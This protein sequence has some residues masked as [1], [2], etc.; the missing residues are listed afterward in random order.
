MRIVSAALLMAMLG[1]CVT[2][3]PIVA[4]TNSCPM[5]I[6]DT[7]REPVAAPP[8][9]E[10]LTVGDWI[11]FADAVVGKLDIANGRNADTLTIIERCTAR[12]AAAVKRS[13]SRFLGVL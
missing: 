5:L 13:R 4:S 9:P 6:P 3:G 7:W 8:L 1:G 11:A 10:G 12:D 2:G